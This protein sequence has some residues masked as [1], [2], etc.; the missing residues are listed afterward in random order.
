M[1]SYENIKMALRIGLYLVR[2]NIKYKEYH[3]SAKETILQRYNR[4]EY[5][6]NRLL[7]NT[8]LSKI[9]KIINT[10]VSSE[11]YAYYPIYDFILQRVPGCHVDLSG[12]IICDKQIAEMKDLVTRTIDELLEPKTLEKLTIEYVFNDPNHFIT[13]MSSIYTNLSNLIFTNMYTEL[14]DNSEIER[15]IEEYTKSSSNKETK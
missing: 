5:K 8:E 13:I 11:L 9:A 1:E 15:I 14:V 12:D 4:I 2:Y 3:K 7:T 6:T 10:N